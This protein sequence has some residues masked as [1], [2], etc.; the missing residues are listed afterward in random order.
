LEIANSIPRKK[1]HLESASAPS[2]LQTSSSSFYGLHGLKDLD[3]WKK[4]ETSEFQN[5]NG[6]KIGIEKDITYFE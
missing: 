5:N 3:I 1:I 2:E 4:I 6:A